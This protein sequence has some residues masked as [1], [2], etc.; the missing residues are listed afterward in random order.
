MRLGFSA[1]SEHSQYHST[2]DGAV[3]ISANE[4]CVFYSVK[5][6]VYWSYP[7]LSPTISRPDIAIDFVCLVGSQ[8]DCP[9]LFVN[10]I[11]DRG[12]RG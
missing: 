2:L 5:S 3:L 12:K 4:I 11:S 8:M 1:Y 6:R 7:F 9:N 10:F